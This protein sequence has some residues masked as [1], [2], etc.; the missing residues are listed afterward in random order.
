M[1]TLGF[2][3]RFRGSEEEI[4]RRLEPYLKLFSGLQ[5]PLPGPVLDVGCGRG[6]LLELCRRHDIPAQGLEHDAGLVGLLRSR[7]L[8]V[9]ENDALTGLRGRPTASLGAVFSAQ[10]IEHLPA[11]AMLQLIAEA[12]RVLAPGGLLVMETLNPS[13]LAMLANTFYRDPGHRQPLHP[14]TAGFILESA[15]FHD[16]QVVTQTPVPQE[17]ALM[18][19]AG[20]GDEELRA[21]INRNV[22]ILNH[23]LFGPQEYHVIGVR[24]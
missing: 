11:G 8:D 4:Q 12:H 13:C 9:E 3:E 23:L 19:V 18:D 14:E 16:V 5:A 21:G 15:G 6:E 1:D 22:R 2:M 7:G 10:V 24:R 20:E 17:H